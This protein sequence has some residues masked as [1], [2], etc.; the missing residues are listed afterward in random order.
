MKPLAAARTAPARRL[1]A[2]AAEYSLTDRQEHQLAR[3]IEA[4]AAEPDPPTTIRSGGEA[5]NG[6]LADSLSGLG[7]PELAGAQRIAD[8]GAGAGFP[9][10][11]L[12]IALPASHVD[13]LE[14]A[15]RKCAVIDRLV[16]AAG[17]ANARA[18]PA[19]AEQWA[20]A[21]GGEG[22]EAVTARALAALA[23]VVEYAAPLL[24]MGGAL[25]A[26]KGRRD[27]GEERAGQRAADRLGLRH[28][29]VEAVT[30]FAAAH[31]RHLH[32]YTKV[33]PTPAGFPRR[34][35]MAVKRP[36]G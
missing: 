24:V 33:E 14:A 15:R 12:A 5:I 16:E 10:L 28:Q 32:V 31:A 30:P 1:A 11:V 13:L 20:L 27:A 22:Y 35:G 23:V 29:R 26:W 8:I 9:G 34:A 4:L 6:H 36:L 17:I 3:L 18:L 21:E 25:V 2:L 19:R 7:V